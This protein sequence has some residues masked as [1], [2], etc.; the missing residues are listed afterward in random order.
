MYQA[1]IVGIF[2]RNDNLAYKWKLYERGELGED[3]FL[4]TLRESQEEV[5][6]VQLEAGLSHIH[7]PY[8]DWHDIFRPF[9]DL[10]EIDIGPITRYFENNTFYKKPVIR[11]RVRYPDGFILNYLHKD[12]M[13]RDRDWV[14]SL[15]GP[16]TFLRLSM[17]KNL[18]DAKASINNILIGS[19]LD[20][21]D[22]GYKVIT[23]HE[24]CLAYY[25]DIDWGL[26]QELYR[27]FDEYGIDI[28]IHLYFGD[29][30]NKIDNLT[31]LPISSFSLDTSYTDITSINNLD[32]NVVV[33]GVLD[34]QNTLIEDPTHLIKSINI[35]KD[36]NSVD[37]IALTPNTDLDFLTFDYAVKKVRLLGEIY[38]RL[39]Q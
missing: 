21:A 20:M 24:P 29:V 22:A 32:K 1:Y 28:R 2:P 31:N 8:I 34:S 12:L 33:L 13:P 4:E 9:T 30:K 38:R 7:D 6:R 36:N 37:T 16:Y 5:I 26:V 23:F 11:G 10:E 17:Y 35:F 18:D 39:G 25:N 19:A 3:E 27:A 14:A 15:P